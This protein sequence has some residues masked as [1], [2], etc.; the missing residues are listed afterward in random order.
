MNVF[1]ME[2]RGIPFNNADSLEKVG[3]G[4]YEHAAIKKARDAAT[5]KKPAADGLP[6]GKGE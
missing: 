6:D 5:I 3:G 1:E 2:S 4:D